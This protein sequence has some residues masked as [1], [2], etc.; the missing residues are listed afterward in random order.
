[1]KMQTFL[2]D[3]YGYYYKIGYLVRAQYPDKGEVYYYNWQCINSYLKLVGVTVPEFDKPFGLFGEDYEFKTHI[4]TACVCDINQGY[5]SEL[6]RKRDIF[7]FER[8]E[9]GVGTFRL[10]HYF[11]EQHGSIRLLT[12]DDGLPVVEMA[13]N[14]GWVRPDGAPTN[15]YVE[16]SPQTAESLDNLVSMSLRE[17]GQLRDS[18]IEARG[19]DEVFKKFVKIENRQDIYRE[20]G[21]T[22]LDKNGKERQWIKYPLRLP[23]KPEPD[24]FP[25]CRHAWLL[26]A[27]NHNGKLFQ[28]RPINP[29]VSVDKD[30]HIEYDSDGKMKFAKYM[31][32]PGEDAD[33]YTAPMSSTIVGRVIVRNEKSVD[34]SVLK[35]AILDNVSDEE[36]GN[37]FWGWVPKSGVEL[38]ITEGFFKAMSLLSLGIVAIGL[39]GMNMACIKETDDLRPGLAAVVGMDTPV[40]FYLD[41]DSKE[42]TID[43]GSAARVKAERAVRKH[44]KHNSDDNPLDGNDGHSN[45]KFADWL[46][47]LGKGIDDVIA[48]GNFKYVRI[49][50]IETD[51][52]TGDVTKVS[53]DFVPAEI[54]A[55]TLFAI[56]MLKAPMSAG[57]TVAMSNYV[58][59]LGNVHVVCLSNRVSLSLDQSATYGVPTLDEKSFNAEDGAACLDSVRKF[60]WANTLSIPE[61]PLMLLIDEYVSAYQHLLVAETAVGVNRIGNMEMFARVCIMAIVSGGGILCSDANMR[62]NAIAFLPGIIKLGLKMM[63]S[64][65]DGLLSPGCVAYNLS[66]VDNAKILLPKLIELQ[67]TIDQKIQVLEFAPDREK[68]NI[69]FT[70]GQAP[71]KFIRDMLEKAMMGDY[72]VIQINTRKRVKKHN[73]ANLVKLYRANIPNFDKHHIVIDGDTINDPD[74][75]AYQ[76]LSI[77]GR[78]NQL[79]AKYRYVFLGSCVDS[80]ISIDVMDHFDASYVMGFASCLPNSVAQMAGRV[81]DPNVRRYV[82]CA[83]RAPYRKYELFPSDVR[84]QAVE[85]AVS[86]T[87][88]HL[89]YSIFN[90]MSRFHLHEVAILKSQSAIEKQRFWEAV[91]YKLSATANVRNIT[92]QQKVE[93]QGD[94]DEMGELKSLSN[95]MIKHSMKTCEDIKQ[96]IKKADDVEGEEIKKIH[97]KKGRTAKDRNE[98]DKAEVRAAFGECEE[99]HIESYLLGHHKSSVSLGLSMLTHKL[100]DAKMTDDLE[101]LSS[102]TQCYTDVLDT[103]Q[104][105]LVEILRDKRVQNFITYGQ[106]YTMQS[107]IVWQLREWVKQYVV[108]LNRNGYSIKPEWINPEDDK[109]RDQV[110]IN[111]I[112]RKFDLVSHPVEKPLINGKQVQH[113]R[114]CEPGFRVELPKEGDE[115]P[116]LSG[117]KMTPIDDSAVVAS[118]IVLRDKLG[119]MVY[120]RDTSSAVAAKEAQT[121]KEA[122]L[123]RGMDLEAA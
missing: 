107:D 36:L 12:W 45:I 31:N 91:E 37:I 104:D 110:L 60:K 41:Q 1:M 90:E 24:S 68:W 28:L 116:E 17:V 55:D 50:G 103:V 62:D 118:W 21:N 73:I 16:L 57:K 96:D 22:Y 92:G 71:T 49:V 38:G 34:C 35:Q 69:T 121:Q 70:H 123:I 63:I 80:G 39:P 81:R 59:S 58:K 23:S 117:R 87:E 53:G 27:Y 66:D 2:K 20:N 4:K 85:K 114:L 40:T 105:D 44:Q 100:V 122:S 47:Q 108:V 113:Y 76:C 98:L 19:I 42:K 84:N 43:N 14:G 95:K 52:I 46:P 88:K 65:C 5:F 115:E 102:G 56:K 120:K 93:L 30:G 25:R 3:S 75:E 11:D 101:N 32:P 106:S 97:Q 79:C 78:L 13:T 29:N 10:V 83:S 119:D 54:L 67:Q 64:Q 61:K 18:L 77:H 6:N 109:P 82:W 15:E 7:R 86:K 89:G 112:F 74:H 8:G 94:K 48:N 72:Q 9:T 33:I 51:D 26:T 99:K 111:H